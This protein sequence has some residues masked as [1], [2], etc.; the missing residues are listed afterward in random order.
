MSAAEET[1]PTPRPEG[2][3]ESG[4]ASAIGGAPTAHNKGFFSPFPPGRGIWV[5]LPLAAILGAVWYFAIHTPEPRDDFGRF[6]G[7]WKLAPDGREKQFPVTVRVAGDQWVYVVGNNEQK[8]YRLT[9]RPE[10]DPKEIDLTQLGADGQP[11]AFILKGIYAFDDGSVK[12]LTA[13][14]PLPRPTTFDAPDGPPVWVMER[15]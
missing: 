15:P 7:T 12:V 1:T 8:K 2:K 6:Q 4:E 9:L 10:A 5:Y 11:S 13:P 14:T 3:G